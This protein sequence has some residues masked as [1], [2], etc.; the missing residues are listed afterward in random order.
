MR[1]ENAGERA[2]RENRFRLNAIC[3]LLSQP[4]DL[5]TPLVHTYKPAEQGVEFPSKLTPPCALFIENRKNAYP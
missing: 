1:D 4:L 2:A 5:L 3:E